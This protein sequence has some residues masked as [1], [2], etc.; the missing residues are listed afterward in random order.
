MTLI[1]PP[2]EF[3][4]N[5][6]NLVMEYVTHATH[7]RSMN[8]D[9]SGTP[10]VF[11]STVTPVDKVLILARAI[12][13]IETSAASSSDLFGDIAGGLTNGIDLKI[14][15]SVIGN[16]KTNE[17]MA[18]ACF[19]FTGVKN[20]GKEDRTILARL[21]FN[22]FIDGASGL[23]ITAGNTVDMVVNDDLSTLLHFHLFLEGF[24]KDA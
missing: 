21:S 12:L 11:S 8:Q 16:F 22:K 23:T 18:I 14:N 7:G 19:D 17:E 2:P 9:G 20:L 13:Y 24:Y 4:A 1:S 3:I 15:G 6:D 10:V 5:E